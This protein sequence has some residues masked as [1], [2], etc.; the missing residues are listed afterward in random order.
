MASGATQIEQSAGSRHDH[1]RAR[2]DTMPHLNRD[3]PPKNH[4]IS[5]ARS[6][7]VASAPEIDD[8]RMTL[9]GPHQALRMWLDL[10]V[11]RMTSPAQMGTT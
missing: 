2:V 4:H 1:K 10:R 7:V 5:C 9:E 8:A 6:V 3:A 11:G